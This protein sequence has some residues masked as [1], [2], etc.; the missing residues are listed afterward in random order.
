MQ[1][2]LLTVVLLCLV[3]LLVTILEGGRRY[4]LLWHCCVWSTCW[5]SSA[6][7]A[8]STHCHSLVVFAWLAGDPPWV[9]QQVLLV[10]VLLCLEDLLVTHHERGRKYLLLYCC[11]R[12]TCWWPSVKESASTHC[13]SLVVFDGLAD[14][15]TLHEGGSMYSLP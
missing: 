4:S 11:V 2:V 5:W 3:D 15:M 6:S 13:H 10:T 9:K 7:K 12:R 14:H 1:Q 8:A